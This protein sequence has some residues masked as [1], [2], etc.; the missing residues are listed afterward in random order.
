MERCPCCKARLAG[1]EVCPRCQADLGAAVSA[2][3]HARYW[4]AQAVRFWAEHE[5]QLAMLA[6]L[7][8][9][10]LKQTLSGQVFC[11]FIIREQGREVLALLAENQSAEAERLLGLLRELQP[12]NELFKQ[13]Q[14]FAGYLAAKSTVPT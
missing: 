2:G 9:L 5:P 4:L 10:R 6:L 1:A 8:A 13:L 12:G 3:H 7:K 11:D 14:G